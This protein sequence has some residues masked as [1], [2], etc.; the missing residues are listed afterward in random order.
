M[1]MHPKTSLGDHTVVVAANSQ[2]DASGDPVILTAGATEDNVEV[3][4]ESI[5]RRQAMSCVLAIAGKAKL[6]ATKTIS[7]GVKYQLSADNSTWDTA[8]VMQAATVA[9]TGGG[10]GTTEDISV[11]LNLSLKGKKKYIRFNITP[12]MSATATDTAVWA[13][14]CS[15]AGFTVLPGT[16]KTT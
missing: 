5:N 16:Q 4:G 15:L 11:E 14:T 2:Q 10:G 3:E 12:D 6:A 13:A 9:A 7:F 8:V 1:T